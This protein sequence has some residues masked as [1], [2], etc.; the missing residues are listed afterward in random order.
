MDRPYLFAGDRGIAVRALEL[1][2]DREDPPLVLC[3]STRQ[4]ATHAAELE[5]RF[6][7]AGGQHVIRG[8]QLRDPETVG[9]LRSQ[10]LDF[11][12]SVHFPDIVRPD[13]LAVPERGWLNL[14]PAYLPFNRGWHTPS[15]AILDGTPAGATLHVMGEAV[16]SG[17][18]VA[19]KQVTIDPSDTAHTLYQRLLEVELNL[20]VE[21]WPTIRSSEPWPT[22]PNDPEEGTRHHSSELLTESVRRIDLGS[23]ARP[24]ELLDRLRALTTDRWSEAAYFERD[25]RRFAV[26]VDIQEAAEAP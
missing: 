4:T 13:A 9:W 8:P 26:R 5:E 6:R 19:R 12:L 20:L 23:T 1:S 21:M 25:G 11:A 10:H 14:H 24:V 3:V 18:I 7:A 2:L 17:P 15:W 16:D 22:T